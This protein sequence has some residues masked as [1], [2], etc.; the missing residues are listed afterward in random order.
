M[1]GGGK[2]DHIIFGTKSSWSNGDK[3]K[4]NSKEY[5]GKYVNRQSL[6]MAYKEYLNVNGG[7]V[8]MTIIFNVFVIYTL[9]NQINCRVIDDSFNILKRI[10]RSSLFSLITFL[11]LAL[12]VL[13][14]CTC[15]YVFHVANNGLTGEQWGICIG[16]SAISFIVSM[17]AKLLPI[18]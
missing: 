8:H 10:T 2:T 7:T 5:C 11:E 3:L 12:Q 13:F 4:V 1:P 14:V 9:F 17:L 16:F 15:K 6:S 18:K